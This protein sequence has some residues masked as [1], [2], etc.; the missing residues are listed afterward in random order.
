MVYGGS[1]NLGADKREDA[2]KKNNSCDIEKQDTEVCIS[3]LPAQREIENR[4]RCLPL[5]ADGVDFCMP[6]CGVALD[7]NKPKRRK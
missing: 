2:V 3:R 7:T 6:L 1:G 5:W 4:P